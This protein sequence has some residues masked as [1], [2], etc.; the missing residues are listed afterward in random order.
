MRRGFI[1]HRHVL[2]HFASW[3]RDCLAGR[4]GTARERRVLKLRGSVGRHRLVDGAY[5][6]LVLHSF[7]ENEA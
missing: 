6:R 4:L 1:G 2:S 7:Q 3:V 5:L